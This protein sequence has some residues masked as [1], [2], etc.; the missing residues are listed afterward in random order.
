MSSIYDS[1]F[2]DYGDNIFTYNH[3]GRYLRV[4]YGEKIHKI[5]IDA[6]FTC[7]N[8]DG[9]LAKGGCIFCDNKIFNDNARRTVKKPVR[10]QIAEA[11]ERKKKVYGVAKFIAYFQAYTNTY[12]NVFHL[13][14]EYDIIRKFPEIIGLSIGTRPDCIDNEK[15]DLIESYSSEYMVWIEY[16][17]QSAND[18]TLQ[19]INRGH[20][21]EQFLDA[22]RITESRRLSICVHTVLGL[23]GESEEDMMKTADIL[24]NL[25]INGIKLH[26]LCVVKNTEL[27]NIYYNNDYTPMT[28][29]EYIKYSVKF[30]E[31]IPYH[32]TIQR[33][34]ADSPD[35][36][37][38]APEWA[39]DRWKIIEGIDAE[40]R[41]RNSMQGILC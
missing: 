40:F 38:I 19:I 4:K 36:I 27:A 20:S 10:A 35:D 1:I 3:F 18:K 25:P 9:K 26:N 17:L 29:E 32:I 22:V 37:F 13:K 23:P 31:R 2:Q 39:K 28:F 33:L 34:T 6:G 24:S 14:K 15:L 16:G 11:I 8:R 30:L 5:I 12:A 21:L 7:P 41:R